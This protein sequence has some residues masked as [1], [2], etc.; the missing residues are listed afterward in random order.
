MPDEQGFK[1]AAEA[2]RELRHVLLD[3]LPAGAGSIGIALSLTDWLDEQHVGPGATI[4]L[5]ASL[6]RH[7]GI[8]PSG[9]LRPIPNPTPPRRRRS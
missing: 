5:A 3:R 8:D 6:R 1:T 9:R 7:V 4:A 2:R